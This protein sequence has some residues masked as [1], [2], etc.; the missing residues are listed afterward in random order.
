MRPSP[1]RPNWRDTRLPCTTRDV[2]I[3]QLSLGT[4][5][6]WL[7]PW[8]VM[9]LLVP[10]FISPSPPPLLPLL[11]IYFLSSFRLLRFILFV[12]VIFFFQ[13]ITIFPSPLIFRQWLFP[14]LL[15]SHPRFTRRNPS[16]LS[17]RNSLL[18]W[19]CG[20]GVSREWHRGSP[21]RHHWA[22]ARSL[23]H[24]AISHSVPFESGEASSSSQ[25]TRCS[26]F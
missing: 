26:C 6:W 21:P 12:L 14:A 10:P 4:G 3:A 2:R 13:H 15:P 25:R 24:L 1:T 8:G 16:L 5:S 20:E 18:H 22:R 11:F 23:Q 19:K 9:L 17:Q 7:R